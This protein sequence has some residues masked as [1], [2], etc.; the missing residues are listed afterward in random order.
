MEYGTEIAG[1]ASERFIT[2]SW[3]VGK[4]APLAR[5]RLQEKKLVVL[6]CVVIQVLSSTELKWSDVCSD[7][8]VAGGTNKRCLLLKLERF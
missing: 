6:V 2:D 5:N 7:I 4:A 1:D 3:S 8:A